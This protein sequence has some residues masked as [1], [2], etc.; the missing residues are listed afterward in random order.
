MSFGERAAIAWLI[1][2]GQEDPPPPNNVRTL[3]R[4]KR[5]QPLDDEVVAGFMEAAEEREPQIIL[6][7]EGVIRSL[8]VK[9]PIRSRRMQ[10]DLNFIRGEAYKLGLP[11][12]KKRW[13]HK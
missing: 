7:M 12:G 5:G 3:S 11:W 8:H 10:R 4:P 9:W 2:S 1:L 13:W 6:E